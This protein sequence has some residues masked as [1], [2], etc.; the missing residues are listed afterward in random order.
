MKVVI[1][2]SLCV[3][4][5]SFPVTFVT[6]NFNTENVCLKLVITSQ[7]V[8]KWEHSNVKNTKFVFPCGRRK[9]YTKYDTTNEHEN[10]T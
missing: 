1:V 2:L 9:T 7:F 8:L 10:V 3:Y 4:W 5:L 6:R